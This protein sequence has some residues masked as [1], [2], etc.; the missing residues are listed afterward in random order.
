M[1]ILVPKT[2]YEVMWER[3][4]ERLGPAGAGEALFDYVLENAYPRLRQLLEEAA[5]GHAVEIYDSD[6]WVVWILFWG[7]GNLR[8]LGEL[9][10]DYIAALGFPW[11][12]RPRGSL[13]GLTPGEAAG[14][15]APETGNPLA[16]PTARGTRGN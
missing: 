14:V 13:G 10:V 11:R 16:C 8:R 5:L 7:N 12:R 9:F 3:L 6:R 15:Q 2:S 4:V 1:K